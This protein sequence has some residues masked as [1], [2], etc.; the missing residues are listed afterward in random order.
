MYYLSGDGKTIEILGKGLS[1]GDVLDKYGFSAFEN[2][3]DTVQDKVQ[4]KAGILRFMRIG[5]DAVPLIQ[6]NDECE[7]EHL[8]CFFQTKLSSGKY[9][10]LDVTALSQTLTYIFRR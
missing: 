5:E 6:Y 1:F 10:D 8:C 9:V 2:V 4:Y 3:S 7:E